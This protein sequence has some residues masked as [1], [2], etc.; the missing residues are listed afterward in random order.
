MKISDF[1]FG[2]HTLLSLVQAFQ[3]ES[4]HTPKR[5]WFCLWQYAEI[6]NSKHLSDTL[7][8]SLPGLTHLTTLSIPHVADD[9]LIYIVSRHLHN[10]ISLDLSSSRVTD[11]GLRFFSSQSNVSFSRADSSS[12]RNTVNSL[13]DMMEI[14]KPSRSKDVS[15]SSSGIIGCPKLERLNLHSC[16]SMTERGIIFA[17]EHFQH[18]RQLDYHQRSSLLEI[19]LKWSS[20][21]SEEQ[22][23]GKVLRLTEI[24]HGFPYGLSPIPSHMAQ[25]GGMLP[26]LTTITLVTTDSCVS[27]LTSFP[28]LSRISVELE[29]C[30]GEGFLTLLSQFGHQLE[31]VCVSC[32][33]DPEAGLSID[34]VDGPAAQQGQLFN[35]AIVSVGELANNVSKLSVS[36]CGLV[37]SA[38]VTRMGLQDKI[39][40]RFWLKNQAEKWFSNLTSLI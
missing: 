32:S 9:R 10:L 3:L 12:T 2:I 29:D 31:E 17:L 34:Q 8:I 39:G 35:L 38:A 11:R 5:L 25:L 26:T 18:L 14:E 23:C 30:L 20:N 40:D 15:E 24:E 6:T 1:Y 22:R 7:C 27:L 28:C 33:S 19:I 36:G 4:L 13:D 21:M 16:E 37:S